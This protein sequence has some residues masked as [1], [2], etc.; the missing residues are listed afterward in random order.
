M[1]KIVS[2]IVTFIILIALTACSSDTQENTDNS[3]NVVTPVVTPE[4]SQPQTPDAPL[5]PELPEHINPLTGLEVAADRE[6]T[7]PYA[8]MLNNIMQA[9]P[10]YGI[11]QANIIYEICAEGGITRM[12]AVYQDISDIGSI[13]SIRSARPYYVELAL[14]LDAIYIHAG[15]SEQ[16]YSDISSKGLTNYDGVRGS[17]EGNMFWRDSQRISTH[18]YE[19]S[20]FITGSHTAELIDGD[21]IRHEHEDG[22]N[23]EM[24]FAWQATPENGYTANKV[25]VEFSSYKTGTFDYD[26]QTRLY[27]ASQYGGAHIDAENGEQVSA[28]NL[29]VLY[30]DERV[31]DGEGRLSVAVIGSGSGKF[32]CGGKGVD[33]LW[34]KEAGGQLK[35]TLED[36][37]PLTCERGSSYVCIISN[38]NNV[39][40]S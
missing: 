25:E 3:P 8:I 15:G 36:G 29:F 18:G 28:S 12:L 10:Q 39:T 16:A 2:V 19:H 7:R 11:S 32:F 40:I 34:S 33:I 9:Q 6:F 26:S 22:Y 23:Y 17:N 31:I 37:T 4:D 35:Y 5:E 38:G 13:G 21:S 1:K 20:L 24:N 14:G 30:T 27:K